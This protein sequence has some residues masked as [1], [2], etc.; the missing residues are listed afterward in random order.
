MRVWDGELSPKLG[1]EPKYVSDNTDGG[2][3]ISCGACDTGQD[4]P[5]VT[6]AHEYCIVCGREFIWRSYWSW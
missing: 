6:S 4:W 5:P 3:H 1:A 2:V